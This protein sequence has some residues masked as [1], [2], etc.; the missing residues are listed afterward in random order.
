MEACIFTTNKV[1]YKQENKHVSFE[2][3]TASEEHV[4]CRAVFFSGPTIFVNALILT[5]TARVPS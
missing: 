1:L 2:I 5:E 3:F 4:L